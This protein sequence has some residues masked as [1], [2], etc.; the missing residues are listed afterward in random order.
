[1]KRRTKTVPYYLIYDPAP[2]S[3]EAWGFGTYSWI[4]AYL[5][6]AAG[7][8]VETHY[9]EPSREVQQSVPGSQR[10]TPVGYSA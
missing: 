9:K 3:E 2:L 7:W 5:Y 1:M 8:K 6:G 10:P 4:D